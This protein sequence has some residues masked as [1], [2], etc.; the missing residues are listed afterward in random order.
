[1]LNAKKNIPIDTKRKAHKL[2]EIA[3]LQGI[4][5]AGIFC[6]LLQKAIQLEE[7][8]ANTDKTLLDESNST[9]QSD[10]DSDDMSQDAEEGQSSLEPLLFE[11]RLNPKAI[12]K[13]QKKKE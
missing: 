3:A 4:K 9:D 7:K 1:M 10:D 13:E 12:K 8:A 5:E 11:Q 6:V 2:V